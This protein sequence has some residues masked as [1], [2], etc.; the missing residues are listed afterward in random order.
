[1]RPTDTR[2]RFGYEE[3]RVHTLPMKVASP[4]VVFREG[5]SNNGATEIFHPQGEAVAED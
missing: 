4:S 5:G 3:A 1:V 2:A